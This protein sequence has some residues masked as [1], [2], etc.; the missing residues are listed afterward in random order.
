MIGS[1]SHGQAQNMEFY[2]DQSITQDNTQQTD[3]LA[4]YEHPRHWNV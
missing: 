1:L 3:H 4:P 2:V